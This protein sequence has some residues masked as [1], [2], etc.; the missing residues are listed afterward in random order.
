MMNFC[1]VNN[2]FLQR[3]K[4]AF[5]LGQHFRLIERNFGTLPTIALSNSAFISIVSEV[6][7]NALEKIAQNFLKFSHL[8]VFVDNK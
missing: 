7:S 5:F 2:H 8:I 6:N 4:L 1:V 3:Y